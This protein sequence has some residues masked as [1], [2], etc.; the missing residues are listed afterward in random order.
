MKKKQSNRGFFI[1]FEGGEGAGKTSLINELKSYL[2][3][4]GFSLIQT[5]EPGSTSLGEKIRQLLLKD[6]KM[7]AYAE[8]A[9]FL[10]S[11]AEHVEKVILP[12]LNEGKIVLCDRYND[13]SIAYQGF[14]RGLGMDA[15][16]KA[17]DFFSLGLTPDLTFYLDI[18]PLIGFKRKSSDV[19]D[20][21][22]EESLFF[23]RNIRKAYYQISKE[24]P[25]RFFLLDASKSK[26]D[27]FNDALLILE[28]KI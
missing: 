23:H 15:V 24:E 20:R 5:R 7:N 4:K 14:A 18:D 9:L 1:T 26:D 19:Y 13:S 3:D 2:T 11:R 6:E 12:A 27:V 16:K 8:L 22:E 28:K 25:N 21:I 17:C 10:A